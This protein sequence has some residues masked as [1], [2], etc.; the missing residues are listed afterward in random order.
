[1]KLRE[2]MLKKKDGPIWAIAQVSQTG[3]NSVGVLNS[4]WKEMKSSNHFHAVPNGM[5]YLEQLEECK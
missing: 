4:S 3:N 2:K 5:G 1:V